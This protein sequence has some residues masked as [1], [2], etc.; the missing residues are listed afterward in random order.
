[1]A[2][3]ELEPVALPC[4][5]REDLYEP[6][7]LPKIPMPALKA[8][9]KARRRG[10]PCILRTPWKKTL[11]TNTNTSALRWGW[12]PGKV[13]AVG[14][15][16]SRY[17]LLKGLPEGMCCR[18]IATGVAERLALRDP[19]TPAF[20]RFACLAAPNRQQKNT[21]YELH[22]FL[23]RI[24][25]EVHFIALFVV[26]GLRSTEATSAQLAIRPSPSGDKNCGYSYGD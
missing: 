25:Q 18:G 14:K 19:V 10:K 9:V 11:A 21:Q 12:M 7:L 15:N 16:V 4:A 22:A 24:Q 26:S 5:V 23:L 3:R 1:M 17:S 13:S 20:R 6:V 2:I 8:I